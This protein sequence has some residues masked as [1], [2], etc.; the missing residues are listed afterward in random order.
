MPWLGMFV[1]FNLQQ[2]LSYYYKNILD[3][4]AFLPRQF[5]QISLEATQ[6]IGT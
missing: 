3:Q 6:V 1:T 4:S 2:H 5:Y